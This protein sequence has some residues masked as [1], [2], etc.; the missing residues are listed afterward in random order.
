MSAQG[1]TIG[2]GGSVVRRSHLIA[3]VM[4]LVLSVAAGVFAGRATSTAT[5]PA[6]SNARVL[7]VSGLANPGVGSKVFPAM[8]RL[9]PPVRQHLSGYSKALRDASRQ[10]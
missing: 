3:V 6:H 8:N 4:L 7:S 9:A 2:V 10:R 5:A 1:A